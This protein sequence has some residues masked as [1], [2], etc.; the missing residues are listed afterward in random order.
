MIK[1]VAHIADIHLRKSPNRHEEYR[2]VFENLYKSLKKEKPD[3]IVIVGDLNH[4]Y[5]E[6]QGEQMVLA[7]EFLNNLSEIAPVRITRGNHDC[8]TGDHEVLT[9]KGWI[10]LE[11]YVDNN[12]NIEVL[13]FNSEREIFEFQKPTDKIKKH[14]NGNLKHIDTE[15]CNFLVTPT[16][17]ILLKNGSKGGYKKEYAKDLTIN[18]ELRIPLSS[19]EH[20]DKKDYWF[21]LLGFCL[22]D[23]TFVIKNKKTMNGRVQFHFKKERKIQYLL[24]LLK[25]LNIPF[26]IRDGD[27]KRGTK[28][29]C[30]YSQS[31]RDLMK[32]FNHSKMLS[33]ELNLLD[34]EKHQIKSFIDG[35]LSGDGSNVENNRYNCV[36]IYKSNSEIL[37]TLSNYIGYNAYIPQNNYA[38]GNYINSKEQFQF[39]INKSEVI[40]S[41]EIRK[42]TDITYE[43]YVF[44]LTVPN[45]NLFIRN[46][47]RCFIT[48]NCKKKA[49]SRMDSVDAIVRNLKNPNVIYYGETGFFNDEDVTWAVWHH[50]DKKSPW[51]KRKKDI[52]NGNI[53]IDLFHDPLVGSKTATGYEFKSKTYISPKNFKGDY[54]MLGDIHQLQYFN[55]NTC[56]Y[57]SSL[58]AQDFGEGDDKFHGCLLWDIVDGKLKEIPIKNDW[59][60]K[61]IVVNPY[62]DF[63]DLDLE[64]DNP[65]KKMRVRIKWQ[66]LPATRTK[67]HEK[68]LVDYLHDY[69]YKE[70]IISISHKNEFI[71]EEGFEIIEE[72][73]LDV[74]NIQDQAVQHEIFKQHLERIGVEESDIQTIIDLDDEISGRLDKED[75]TNIQ[76]DIVKLWSSNFMSYETLDIDWRD[77]DGLYQIAGENTAGK[78]TIMKLITYILYNKTLETETQMKYGDQRYVNNRNGA[79]FCE[80]GMVISV[81]GEY[82]GILR[83]T[84]LGFDKHGEI[85]SSPTTLNY[86]MLATP[87]DE[88]NNDNSIESLN[89]KDRFQTQSKI[90][91][92]I[93]TYANF[94]RVVMTTSDTLNKIL[95][96]NKAEFIDSILHDSG[97]D[98]FDKKLSEFKIYEKDI[99]AK[100]RV[101]CNVAATE[102]KIHQTNIHSAQLNNE[103]DELERK[104]IPDE[105]VAIEK[106]GEYIEQLIKKLYKIDNDIYNLNIP[107]TKNQILILNSSK[108]DFNQRLEKLN[109][110]ISELKESYDVEKLEKLIEEKDKNISKIN[111]IKLQ[112]KEEERKIIEQK[113]DKALLNGQILQ[114]KEKG[115]KCKN[116]ILVLKESKTCPT[117][118][119]LMT[120]EHQVHIDSKIKE[121]EDEMFNTLA[122][123]IKAKLSAIP[124]LDGRVTDLHS[125]INELNIEISN[126]NE[127]GVSI[128]EEIGVLK[129]EKQDVEI[130]K[131]LQNEADNIPLQIENIDLKIQG[132]EQKLLL[133]ENM[134]LQ[135]AEN[136]KIEVGILKA[137]ERI[138]ELTNSL[139]MHKDMA[140]NKKM[141][142]A[143]N[144]ITVREYNNLI[145]EYQEQTKQDEIRSIYKQC[146]HRD[147]IPTQ[148]LI[149]H[150]IPKINTELGNLLDNV[151]FS[152]WLETTDL[153]LKLAYNNRIDAVIDAISSSGKERTFSSVALKF[154]LN[155][156]NAKSKPTMFLLDEVMGKLDENSVEEFILVLQAIKEKM[157][158][159]LVVEHNHETNPDYLIKVTK[160]SND[161]S[162]LVIE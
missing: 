124:E 16:H 75:F 133:H 157:K 32:F 76:W 102:E 48:G 96:N 29:I 39:Y 73:K 153:K 113:N 58:I 97:L 21:E 127:E 112:I 78:T 147:G 82:Y 62:T 91:K 152:V 92:A 70:E 4:D 77:N 106:G 36:S 139:Q 38:K 116:E 42:I 72:E 155:Q 81:N 15:K 86:H 101:S 14:Y 19:S 110:G 3:R 105:E 63:E 27:K 79:K 64:I 68:A 44:C 129:N 43:G 10:S 51:T 1:K 162:H 25:L 107:Q 161:I 7:S 46:N 149:N 28:V 119:Q 59:S 131:E 8:F 93:G 141:Y 156:I 33:Y 140:N 56:A 90:E 12:S 126:L 11:D 135:I 115:V 143:Q 118:G 67:E 114:L 109:K 13:T 159:I 37:T 142:L 34:L 22:A 95:S 61:T 49:L 35:Y 128:I 24:D 74:D 20:I 5:I 148:L 54:A 84:E 146:V 151:P 144:V 47:N 31:A 52:P 88:F 117:C 71:E 69:K 6:M 87:D 17:E 85:N 108:D 121:I 53:I 83:R 94:N 138:A 134:G 103:L 40:K 80:G 154:A 136:Q 55:D 45:E 41:T 23:A 30:I 160:N 89:E 18:K 150:A 65:T 9:K 2:N 120:D 132:Y 137:K 60:F 66:T 125:T 123:Q 99:L 100:P 122:P 50:G 130:R 98:I 104:I 158:I 26:T 145:A 111:T 57:P